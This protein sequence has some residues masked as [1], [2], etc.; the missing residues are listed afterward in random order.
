MCLQPF[1]TCQ[2]SSQCCS[3]SCNTGTGWCN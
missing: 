1:R 3:G 2:K